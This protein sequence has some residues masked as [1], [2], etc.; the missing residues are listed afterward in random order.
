M[1]WEHCKSLSRYELSMFNIVELIRI[2]LLNLNYWMLFPID[3]PRFCWG[4]FH[5]RS[6]RIQNTSHCV[7][8]NCIYHNTL[9]QMFDFS[10]YTLYFLTCYE[11]WYC[12]FPL[13][14]PINE[15][16]EFFGGTSTKMWIWSGHA[17]FSIG[18]LRTNY[19]NCFNISILLIQ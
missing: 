16:I 2:W 4:L 6:I 18:L 7:L 14:N 8:F 3:N 19:I 1:I 13:D 9:Y 17:L 5:N 15:D 12:S 11:S 10:I